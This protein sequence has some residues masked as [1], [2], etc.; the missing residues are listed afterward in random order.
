MFENTT[1]G[2]GPFLYLYNVKR[3][4]V[5]EQPPKLEKG[6]GIPDNVTH[7]FFH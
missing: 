3:P 2:D 4:F 6:V 5:L 1:Q 7:L